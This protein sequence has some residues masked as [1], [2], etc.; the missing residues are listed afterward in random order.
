MKPKKGVDGLW[1]ERGGDSLPDFTEGG[2]R[3]NKADDTPLG[4][5]KKM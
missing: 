5:I 1:R 3:E 4:R 2:R